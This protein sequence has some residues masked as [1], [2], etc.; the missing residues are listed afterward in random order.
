MISK[1]SHETRSTEIKDCCPEAH[2]KIVN[3]EWHRDGLTPEEMALIVILAPMARNGDP[4][5]DD[6]IRVPINSSGVVTICRSREDVN[7]WGSSETGYTNP[8]WDNVATVGRRLD[9]HRRA[10]LGVPF[11]VDGRDLWAGRNDERTD[12][13]VRAR[14]FGIRRGE[15]ELTHDRN[16]FRPARATRNMQSS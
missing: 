12:E 13:G 5:F 3:S 14:R 16:A 2:Q 8:T 11:P 1:Y 10:F 9:V 15:L 6:F 7:I 4:T